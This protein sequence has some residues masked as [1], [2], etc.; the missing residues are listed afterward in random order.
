[1]TAESDEPKVAIGMRA[2]HISPLS[3]SDAHQKYDYD[4]FISYRRGDASQLAHWIRNKL[5]RTRLPLEIVAELSPENKELY[6]RRPQIWLDT[7]YEKSSDDFLLKKVFPALDKS[8][9]LIVVSTPLALESIRSSDG[10]SENNWLVREIDHF[11]GSL[12]TSLGERPI[13]LVFGPGAVEGLYPGRLSERERWDWIDLREYNGWRGSTFSDALDDGVT[14]LVAALYDVPDRYLPL[15]RREEHRRRQRAILGFAIAGFCIAAFTTALAIWGFSERS[16]ALTALQVALTTRAQMSVR[17]AAEEL[18]KKDPDHALVAGLAGVET[19]SMLEPDHALIGESITA[20]SSSLSEETFGATLRAHADAVLRAFF[21]PAGTSIVTIG[22]DD[23]VIAWRRGKG[24]AIRPSG[25]AQLAGDVF[26]ATSD[27]GLVASGSANGNVTFWSAPGSDLSP[28]PYNFG[29]PAV[30]LALSNDQQLAAGVGTSGKLVVWNVSENETVWADSTAGSSFIAFG[31][32]CNCLVLGLATGDLQIRPLDRKAP[33]ELVHGA[34]GKVTNGAFGRA[35]QFVFSTD[36]GRLWLTSEHQWPAAIGIGRHEGGV[37]DIAVS[38]AAD[39]A[40]TA[41]VDGVVRFW[42]LR[43]GSE[44]TNTASE[45]GEAV[46]RVAFA[47][48]GDSVA[49]AYADG[50]IALWD[51]SD[52][53]SPAFETLLLRGHTAPILDLSFSPD[54]KW[55]LSASLDGTARLWLV[56]TASVS[57]SRQAHDGPA[58]NALAS[59]GHWALTAGIEDKLV[60]L[61]SGPPWKPIYSISVDAPPSKL[62]LSAD[63]RRAFIGTRTG[64][65]LQWQTDGSKVNRISHDNGV[66]SSLNISPDQATLSAIGVNG[67]L[68]V[69]KIAETTSQCA[70]EGPPLGWGYSVTSSEDGRW[71]GASGGTEGGSGWGLVWDLHANKGFT[72]EGHTDRVLSIQF[73]RSGERAVTAS[74]DGTARIWDLATGREIVRIEEQKGRLSTAGFSPDGKWI[75]TCSYDRTI[76]IWRVLPSGSASKLIVLSA[77]D[78]TLVSDEFSVG[79]IQFDPTGSLLAAT[80]LTGDIKL[81]HMPDGVPRGLL[82]GDGSG[83]LIFSF[84]PDGSQLTG[85]TARGRLLRWDVSP[86]LVVADNVLLSLARGFV[87]LAGSLAGKLEQPANGSSG[88]SETCS[89]ER[90]HYIGLPPHRLSG[91]ARARQQVII[92]TGCQSGS[93]SDKGTLKGGLIAEAEGDFAT[94]ASNFN[95]AASNGA[96]AALIGLGDLGFVDEFGG[97]GLTDPLTEYTRARDLGAPFSDSR[98]GWLLLTTGEGD[99]EQIKSHFVRSI[100][101]G[102]ADGFAGLAWLYQQ[103]SLSPKDLEMAFSQYINAQYAYERDGDLVH[104]QQIAEQRSMLAQLLAPER[105][106]NSFLAARRSIQ[107]STS[108]QQ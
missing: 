69:C 40:A 52:A 3:K 2:G 41:G 1:M 14:K 28:K 80:L 73:D 66:I 71:I 108:A 91:A 78:G 42:D 51:I 62:A 26:A 65:I 88:A 100:E 5:Q 23:R 104:A 87:P 58:I 85:T 25:S 107:M 72:L 94:A 17:L 105:V 95:A 97:E 49:L 43:S 50:T 37:T 59:G 12:P 21:G 68:Q 32:T 9:R 63:G 101:K 24:Q 106:A 45:H 70:P 74:W 103:H 81:W 92:P 46:T 83:T 82:K 44:V 54:G 22:A 15:L 39:F 4:A 34:S 13:D 93:T 67:T 89:Y 84:Q 16:N 99:L 11:V 29:E 90:E 20:I 36:D 7:S 77:R 75:A 31:R 79:Q 48:N 61:W 86:A 96:A 64:D 56:Q 8:A 27:G 102:D 30:M 19:P 6:E 55:L 10:Q 33:P 57:D 47:P 38:P 98:L 76:R 53:R 18:S 60:R 35:G